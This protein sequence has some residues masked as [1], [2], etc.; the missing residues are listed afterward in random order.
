M[1]VLGKQNPVKVKA[2]PS[3]R[4]LL[5]FMCVCMLF[6]VEAELTQS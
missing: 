1:V 2:N 4:L 3:R 5:L 6:S